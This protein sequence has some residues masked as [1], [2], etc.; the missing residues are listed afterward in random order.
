[1]AE[2]RVAPGLHELFSRGTREGYLTYAEINRALPADTVAAEHIDELMELLR[3]SDVQIVVRAPG[4][5]KAAKEAKAAKSKKDA[6]DGKAIKKRRDEDLEAIYKSNDPVRL[7]LRK[8]GSVS[9]LTREGEVEIA[10]RIETG[11]KMV[12]GAAMGSVIAVRE[13]LAIGER[14][15]S[16]SIKLKDAI[17]D[18]EINPE[19][20]SDDERIEELLKIV[21]SVKRLDAEASKLQERIESGTKLSAARRDN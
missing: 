19:E 15:R 6:R 5:K 16:R 2:E 13:A 10:K 4:S 21:D 20:R 11:E 3:S 18:A 8:M 1:M 9:L 14:L 12:Q 7:Y 17:R